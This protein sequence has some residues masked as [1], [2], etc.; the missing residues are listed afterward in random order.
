VRSKCINFTKPENWLDA[1][2][3]HVTV[4]ASRQE[5]EAKG[6]A[7]IPLEADVRLYQLGKMLPDLARHMDTLHPDD[8]MRLCADLPGLGR[9]LSAL[10]RILPQPY[11]LSWLVVGSRLEL[12]QAA[13]DLAGVARTREALEE[14]LGGEQGALAA[15]T[16]NPRLLT[17]RAAAVREAL[18]AL[19]ELLMGDGDRAAGSARALRAVAVNPWLMGVRMEAALAA[20][21][22][23]QDRV[24]AE[25]AGHW[26]NKHP[27]LLLAHPDTL[28]QAMDTM[29][30]LLGGE[31]EA[32]LAVDYS[33]GLIGLRRDDMLRTYRILE[34]TFGCQGASEAVQH[35][36]SLLGLSSARLQIVVAE[37][38]ST[39]GGKKKALEVLIS[40]SCRIPP[41]FS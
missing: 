30:E 38:T 16:A 6:A 9:R 37:L 15:T 31:G 36:P 22:A 32:L 23:L 13:T 33:P 5:I 19:A 14:V 39:C 26:I 12:A 28:P 4:T 29:V 18:P 17:A 35:N 2:R 10:R 34:T 24:G 7:S 1:K 21:R 27:G 41:H 25:K 20:K 40:Q 11:D 3:Q 8:V